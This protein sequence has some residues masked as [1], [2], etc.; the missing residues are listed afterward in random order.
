MTIN[1]IQGAYGSPGLEPLS[2]GGPATEQAARNREIARAVR[3]INEQQVYGPGS[4]LRFS[5]DHQTGHSLIRIVDRSTNE[6]LTQIPPEEVIRLS[7]RLSQL[8]TSRAHVA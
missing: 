3:N 5:V 4:E 8:R 7:A 2:P 6:V 1:Q